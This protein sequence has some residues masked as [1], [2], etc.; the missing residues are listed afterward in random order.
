MTCFTPIKGYR[1]TN[2][3]ITFQRGP[4]ST[5]QL[6]EVSCK[7]CVGCLNDRA[8]SWAVRCVHEDRT[9]LEETGYPG[10]FLTLTYNDQNLPP[11]GSISRTEHQKFIRAL[12]DHLRP[13]GFKNLRYFMC[14]E[15]GQDEYWRDEDDPTIPP[16]R[17]GPGRPHYHYLIF[18]YNFPDKEPWRVHRGHQYYRSATLEKIWDKG[19]SAIGHITPETAAYTARY[20]IKKSG[21]IDEKEM[22]YSRLIPETGEWWPVEEEF[23]LMS[24]KP[25]IGARWFEK[26]GKYDVYQTGDFVEIN[27]RKYQTPKYY[28]TL[29][30]KLDPEALFEVKS[31]R[32]KRAALNPNNTED[33]LAIR[34]E[35]ARLK[36]DKLKRGY[37]NE[38]SYL[39]SS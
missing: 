1:N 30:E 11:T 9:S 27:G 31:D 7:Q 22:H 36:I 29:L 17:L 24:L 14:G 8:K 3:Q 32:K 38:S 13:K 4:M 6:T 18:G 34:H 5:G 33:R 21:R 23:T 39:R 37:E 2:G 26:H 19:H 12:R 25:G 20:V 35:V 15:Y 16:E 28:D 10:S